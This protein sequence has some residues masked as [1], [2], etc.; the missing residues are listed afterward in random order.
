M[1]SILTRASGALA[2]KASEIWTVVKGIFPTFI[3]KMLLCMEKLFFI[4]IIWKKG[5]SVWKPVYAQK[6]HEF[7]KPLSNFKRHRELFQAWQ[8][9][10]IY[11]KYSLG[12]SISVRRIFF[13]H[14]VV[15]YAQEHLSH[16]VLW[17]HYR[18]I[19][20]YFLKGVNNSDAC[21]AP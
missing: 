6:P 5:F 7:L 20:T 12:M 14:K 21:Y 18:I 1:L 16:C 11:F 13:A 8:C 2:A 19:F 10:S 9:I 3:P 15:S 4:L 17:L